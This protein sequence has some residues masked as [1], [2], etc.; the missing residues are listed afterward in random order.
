MD[1]GGG[2]APPVAADVRNVMIAV[3]QK[4]ATAGAKQQQEEGEGGVVWEEEEKDDIPMCTNGHNSETFLCVTPKCF[5]FACARLN[6]CH[7]ERLPPSCPR[8]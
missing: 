8:G 6:C 2:K 4:G 3:S 7:C 1:L 5:C